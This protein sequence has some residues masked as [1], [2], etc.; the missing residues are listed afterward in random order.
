[1]YEGRYELMGEQKYTKE[2]VLRLAK[3]LN[4][5][6]I[7]LQFT[8]ILGIIKN[9]SIPVQQLEK[10]L[11]GELMFDGSSIEGFV[12]IEESDMYL[13]PDP[14]TFVVYPWGEKGCG[15][16]ARLICDIYKSDGTPFEGCP[17]LTLKRVLAEAQEMG[18]TM[19]VGPE[20]EFFLFL[21][22]AN[23]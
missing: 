10:A 3:E 15:V 14:N 7:R 20:A 11:S 8:D 6:F 12:R 4:V 16:V 21:K 22:D 23:E 5:R 19:N 1:M 9:V 2:D 18:F 13:K 17:R